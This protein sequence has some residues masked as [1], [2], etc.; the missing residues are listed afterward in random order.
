MLSAAKHLHRDTRGRKEQQVRNAAS[1]LPNEQLRRERLRRGW[2]REYVAEQIGLADAKTIGRWE[3]GVAFPST[4]FL[5]KLCTLFGMLAQDLGLFPGGY[6]NAKP[7]VAGQHM[8]YRT[9]IFSVSTSPLYDPAIP[10]MLADT[11]GLVDRD[12]L[13]ELLKQCLCA[14]KRPNT[15]ALHGLPGVGKTTLAREILYDTT[16]QQY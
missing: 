2:S 10:Q 3:R 13:Q 5:Q 12:E 16:I 14:G 15:S 7:G 9:G 8:F 6:D 4:Y 1:M 11:G